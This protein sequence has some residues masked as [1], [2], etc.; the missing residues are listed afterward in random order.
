MPPAPASHGCSGAVSPNPACIPHREPATTRASINA[1]VA[2]MPAS[3]A[4]AMVMPFADGAP[5]LTGA[6]AAATG[7]AGEPVTDARTSCHECQCAPAVIVPATPAAR[8]PANERQCAPAVIVPAPPPE[9]AAMSTP[10]ATAAAL[11]R[12][13]ATGNQV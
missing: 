13:V 11:R 6:D 5:R 1:R 12:R 3:A 4:A 9:A 10:A 7:S 8:P 2:T